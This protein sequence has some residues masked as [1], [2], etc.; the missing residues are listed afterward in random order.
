MF[1]NNLF[2]HKIYL[3]VSVSY[4]ISLCK[5]IEYINNYLNRNMKPASDKGMLIKTTYMGIC[6][7]CTLL[8]VTAS[9]LL[10]APDEEAVASESS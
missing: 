2:C 4:R 10:S 9:S 5:S 8:Y 3:T 1:L 6:C 7:W